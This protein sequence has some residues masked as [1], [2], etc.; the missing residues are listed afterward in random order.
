MFASNQPRQPLIMRILVRPLVYRH[1]R[2]WGSVCL[3]AGSWVFVLG[4][5]LCAYGFWWGA[6]LMAVAALELWIGYRLLHSEKS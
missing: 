5:I 1:P 2:A 3:A 4:T 6:S